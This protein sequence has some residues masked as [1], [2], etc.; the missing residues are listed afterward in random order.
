MLPANYKLVFERGGEMLINRPQVRGHWPGRGCRGTWPFHPGCQVASGARERSSGAGCRGSSCTSVQLAGC[1]VWS[2][3]LCLFRGAESHKAT[4]SPHRNGHLDHAGCIL[5]SCHTT[6]SPGGQDT[7][8]TMEFGA[9]PPVCGWVAITGHCSSL[10]HLLY[11]LWN[12]EGDV[13]PA[14][15]RAGISSQPGHNLPGSNTGNWLERHRWGKWAPGL[16]T[17]L[18]LLPLLASLGQDSYRANPQLNT[19]RRPCSLDRVA[20]Q[21]EERAAGSLASKLFSALF[22]SSKAEGIDLQLAPSL[23]S[24]SFADTP[25]S[26]GAGL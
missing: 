8:Q 14:P 23:P 5:R 18:L 24:P 6:L 9:A 1:P 15:R 25:G 19:L 7:G 21:Q 2:P 13:I 17:P 22:N 4:P 3:S 16:I 20:P 10:P 26:V 12:C 11:V